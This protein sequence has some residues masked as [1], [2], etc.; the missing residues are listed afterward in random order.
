MR[1]V[2]ALMLA[3]LCFQSP[4]TQ[5]GSD[6]TLLEE[7]NANKS[8]QR[9]ENN[10]FEPNNLYWEFLNTID[11]PNSNMV[12]A[13]SLLYSGIDSYC[14]TS[15][16]L[17]DMFFVTSFNNDLVLTKIFS[18]STEEIT[19]EQKGNIY[20]TLNCE[21]SES[22]E[23]WIAG[24]GTNSTS[25]V[26]DVF[27]YNEQN[28]LQKMY[29]NT[30]QRYTYQYAWSF[31]QQ[32]VTIIPLQND[33]A[34]LSYIDDLNDFESTS[35]TLYLISIG[36]DGM[37]TTYQL[38][39]NEV[40]VNTQSQKVIQ[41]KENNIWFCYK[42]S[43]FDL[44]VTKFYIYNGVEHIT[45][46]SM[47]NSEIN[48]SANKDCSINLI[49]EEVSLMC[50][51][52]TGEISIWQL[53]RINNEW[54]RNQDL[55][56]AYYSDG[57]KV[58]STK[59][60]FDFWINHRHYNS[61]WVSNIESFDSITVF[62]RN[63]GLSYPVS[64]TIDDYS[65]PNYY[66]A[67]LDWEGQLWVSSIYYNETSNENGIMINRFFYDNDSDG[68]VNS[69]DYFPD[70]IT[71]W[72]DFDGDGYGDN[73]NGFKGDDCYTSSGNSHKG[74]VFGC[75][76]SDNDGYADSIDE[77][78]LEITQWIDNDKDG[79]GDNLSGLN[80]DHFPYDYTQWS[81]LDGDGYGD[82][83][84][85]R[86]YD[87]FP[88]NPT[89]WEDS[90]GDG[91]GDNIS[92]TNADRYPFDFDNDGY[93][94]S[95]DILPKFYSPNDLD[96]DGCLDQ[97]DAFPIDSK[98][99]V[100]TDG[101]GIGNYADMDDDGDGWTDSDELR[102]GTDSLS[103]SDKPVD[104]FEIIFPGT[105]V[106]LGAWDL[107]GIFA[108][109][110]MVLWISFG[111]ITRN[112]RCKKYEELLVRANSRKELEEVALK[113][114]FSLMLRLIG[115]HQGI[116][117]ERLRS[118]LDDQ[119][120]NNYYTK[121]GNF[122]KNRDYSTNDIKIENEEQIFSQNGNSLIVDDYGYEWRITENSGKYYRIKNSNDDW[123]L[124]E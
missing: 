33:G 55:S 2:F 88:N 8:N 74:G 50:E 56:F 21:I 38:F 15:N 23:L 34:L 72:S 10:F 37:N 60:D 104:S 103:S 77:F 92:G 73:L 67:D 57:I 119:F 39:Q 102:L 63:G 87:F 4:L 3:V 17:G 111:L 69:L 44:N 24:V 82:N 113:W 7:L 93:N 105:S 62:V 121:K 29:N 26:I 59:F 71:Q 116:R 42:T 120:G 80:G 95:I 79:F 81:D 108:G 32:V 27:R 78:P 83:P 9:I 48:M 51:L 40:V 76:D 99:C 117:L 96:A 98:E 109:I 110:P 16:K 28:G 45:N 54:R 46:Y 1:T 31:A 43:E 114:E 65:D 58:V 89:Q 107:I 61:G 47:S 68:Y 52:D 75:Q 118:E 94:D 41:D 36:N 97:E 18:E 90:D 20:T 6:Y 122:K 100:D 64:L 85:G 53:D 101:D 115:P 19:F 70:E 84:Q 11:S 123:K 22:N 66:S 5:L 14:M 86:F 106:G 35:G 124:H 12:V 13:T 25:V 30:T 112:R 49:D 91:F